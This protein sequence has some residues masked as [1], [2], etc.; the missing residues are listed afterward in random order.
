MTNKNP[1]KEKSVGRDKG[2]AVIIEE[3]G[4]TAATVTEH[5]LATTH[6]VI[7]NVQSIQRMPSTCEDQVLQPQRSAVKTP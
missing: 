1:T 3:F 5:C 2:S 6:N 4:Q 7:T